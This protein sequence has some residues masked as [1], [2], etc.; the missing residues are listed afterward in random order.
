L[1]KKVF[2]LTCASP[3]GS[4]FGWSIYRSN[5]FP[6]LNEPFRFATPQPDEAGELFP[7]SATIDKINPLEKYRPKVVK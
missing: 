3:L 2:E 6:S 1:P 5:R 7:R 4:Q